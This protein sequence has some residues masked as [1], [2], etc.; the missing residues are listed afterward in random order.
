MINHRLLQSVVFATTVTVWFPGLEAEVYRWVNEQGVTV[1]SQTPPAEPRETE[2][3]TPP[4]APPGTQDETWSD[5]NRQW[6]AMQD[7]ED[8]RKDT[9]SDLSK[10]RKREESRATNCQAARNNLEGLDQ[11]IRRIR[12]EEPDGT[13]RRLTR[14]E[15]QSRMEEARKMIRENCD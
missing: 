4:P 7:R 3:I 2:K 6:Q 8:T 10:Q 1:Y 9:E 12:V 15:Q 13:V 14:E 5:L 11:G